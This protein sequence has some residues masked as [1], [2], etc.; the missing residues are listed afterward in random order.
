M[1]KRVLF[2]ESWDLGNR[3]FS[4]LRS[5]VTP[6]HKRAFRSRAV[7]WGA[8][9]VH[10]RVQQFLPRLHIDATRAFAVRITRALCCIPQ[11]AR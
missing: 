10:T 4:Q 9:L 8:G 7:Q 6:T 1:S 3:R 2:G 5:R 11:I